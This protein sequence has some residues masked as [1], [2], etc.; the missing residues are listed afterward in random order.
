MK[1]HVFL[2]DF[3]QPV[4]HALERANQ[5]SP[6]F[7][8]LIVPD[9]IH[10]GEVG[11]WIMAAELLSQWHV[12]PVVSRVV[13]HADRA[14]VASTENAKVEAL[15]AT[16]DGLRWIETDQALPLPLDPGDVLTKFL[17]KISDIARLDQQIVQVDSLAPGDFELVIDGKAAGTFSQDEWGRG[18]NIALCST[19]MLSQARD[20]EWHE[21]RRATLDQARFI[22]SAEIT[23]TAGSQAAADA[24]EQGQA[25]LASAIRSSMELK[26]HTFEL[27]RK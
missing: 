13:L 4:V 22:L 10:P 6:D 12:N 27:R 20:V 19:P 11:H 23:S 7:A 15:Q 9:R 26:P 3:Y 17:L 2:A 18:V 14:S 24:L 25:E 16:G 1:N 8:P 5:Q 21:Q